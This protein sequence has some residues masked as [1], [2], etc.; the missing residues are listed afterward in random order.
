MSVPFFFFFFNF[1]IKFVYYR[2]NQQINNLHQKIREN[3]IR[4]QHA[5]LSHLV[6]CEDPY[7]TNLQVG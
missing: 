1:Q 3:E 7:L 5:R 2:Q 6:N 4:A